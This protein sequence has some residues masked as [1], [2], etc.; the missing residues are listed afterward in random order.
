MGQ[1]QSD[2]AKRSD[3]MRANTTRTGSKWARPVLSTRQGIGASET[4][5]GFGG[6]EYR[7]LQIAL[8]TWREPAHGGR[9]VVLIVG[10]HRLAGGKN[11]RDDGQSHMR[12]L[13]VRRS[14][15]TVRGRLAVSRLSV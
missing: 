11:R 9:G 7:E 15:A 4:Q 5:C 8:V 13:M 12:L 3:H 10:L 14:V 2:E 6:T 1:V